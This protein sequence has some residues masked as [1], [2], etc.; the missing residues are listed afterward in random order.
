MSEISFGL[1]VRVCIVTGGAQGIGEG[2]IHG[3]PV[4]SLA[5]NRNRPAVGNAWYAK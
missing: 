3:R 4:R 5:T 1:E 2:V